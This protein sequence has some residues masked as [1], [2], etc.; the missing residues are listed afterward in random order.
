MID[1]EQFCDLIKQNERAMYSLAYSLVRNDS[2]AQEVISESIYR[3]FY[4]LSS[5]KSEKAFK[6]WVL[7]IVHNTAVELIRKN[8]RLTNLDEIDDR[9]DITQSESETATRLALR[10]AVCSLRE[11]Y[12]TVITLFYY[13]ELSVSQ[14]ADITGANPVSVRQQL[15]RGRKM[16]RQL[17]KEDFI[18]E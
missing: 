8:S 13:E 7:S 15:T 3:A 1:K 17:L 4:H 14:I 2:D 10:D 6:A 16:L 9:P 11:P 5:L 12:S 18:N